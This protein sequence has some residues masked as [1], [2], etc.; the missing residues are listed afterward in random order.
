MSAR[1]YSTKKLDLAG[2]RFGQLTVLR[3]GE[4]IGR[5]TAWVCR[6]DCG[7]EALVRTCYLRRGKTHSC[8]CADSEGRLAGTRRLDLTGQ[9]FGKLVAVEPLAR[10]P[11][12]S[13]KWR[14]VC[15]CGG[16][17]AATVANLRNGHSR[18]CG[19]ESKLLSEF[20]HYVD[21][22]AVELIRKNPI[23]SNNTSG[24]TGVVW[25]KRAGRWCAEIGFKGQRHY[26]GLYTRFEDAVHARKEA[27]AR[28]FG[29][30]L[31]EYD[32]AKQ[33]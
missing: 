28:Y 29:T 12:H 32:A 22:T 30:F 9:R 13:S 5:D 17:C 11:G 6:C 3:R 23:R 21:G 15:D 7:R 25:R 8:G 31:A 18:S 1:D 26:L 2:Q 4:N 16:E 33:S 10:E 19:C 14:C 27:E 20:L 24:V